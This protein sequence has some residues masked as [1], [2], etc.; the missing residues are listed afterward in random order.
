MYAIFA[1]DQPVYVGV[2]RI[3]VQRRLLTHWY[4]RGNVNLARASRAGAT[5]SMSFCY[6]LM[7]THIA[8]AVEATLIEELGG[9]EV[10]GNLI[11][12]TVR[13]DWPQDWKKE[14][15]NVVS[16]AKESAQYF[17]SP[18]KEAI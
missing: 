12:R 16:Q 8:W 6:W 5:D 11:G 10:L 17:L 18:E 3:D 13:D 15:D 9:T 14:R 7:N 2:S 4:K 1:G